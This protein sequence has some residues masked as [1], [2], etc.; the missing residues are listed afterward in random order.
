MNEKVM[1]IPFLLKKIQKTLLKSKNDQQCIK[2]LSKISWIDN[3]RKFNKDLKI[4]EKIFN[5]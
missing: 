5:F 1:R 3:S 4:S 2:G